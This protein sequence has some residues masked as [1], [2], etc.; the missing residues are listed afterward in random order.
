MNRKNQFSGLTR[1]LTKLIL[2]PL[3]LQL[4]SPASADPSGGILFFS[5]AACIK[6]K[7]KDGK[8][9]IDSFFDRLES[10]K[11]EPQ[12][13]SKE[14]AH[15]SKPIASPVQERPWNLN[16]QA[17]AELLNQ[18]RS[19]KILGFANN[20]P[21]PWSS[22]QCKDGREHLR[23]EGTKV[24]LAPNEMAF[25]HGILT[26]ECR[27]QHGRASGP[28]YR[29]SV[30]A[31][32]NQLRVE[33]YISANISADNELKNYERFR[34]MPTDDKAV[35]KARLR[36][37]VRQNDQGGLIIEHFSQPA[38]FV[39][40]WLSKL[41][42]IKEVAC[43]AEKDVLV[44]RDEESWCPREVVESI[45]A[46]IKERKESLSDDAHHQR[47]DANTLSQCKKT[48]FSG[49]ARVF[50]RTNGPE[51]AQQRYLVLEE[52][53]L[54]GQR[55]REFSHVFLPPLA[56]SPSL[57]PPTAPPNENGTVR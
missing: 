38:C 45:R 57:P 3:I 46:D 24:N 14:R 43:D 26:I 54:E 25:G 41:V 33:D 12:E 21:V 47:Q 27:D 10:Q 20:Q 55:I 34:I 7:I 19:Q 31:M 13:L 48:S 29:L 8:N 5:I 52:E 40:K 44:Y 35:Y 39:S 9:C 23:F 4:P 49:G 30:R 32:N 17:A 15:P 22:A 53:V 18:I 37:K 1:T 51:S 28:Y 6:M 42:L 16:D 2:V 50:L 56:P 36:K 11:P